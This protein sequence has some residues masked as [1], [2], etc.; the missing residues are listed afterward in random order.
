MILVLIF[1]ILLTISLG[2][3]VFLL[4]H[5]MPLLSKVENLENL[6][7]KKRNLSL[8]K[9]KDFLFKRTQ[10][11]KPLLKEKK[12]KVSEA[13]KGTPKKEGNKLEQ[14][15]QNRDYWDKVSE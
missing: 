1:Q 6:T 7:S 13:I 15:E 12:Q 3:M 14:I 11:L 2:G 10:G 4:A 9:T 5:K 8:K